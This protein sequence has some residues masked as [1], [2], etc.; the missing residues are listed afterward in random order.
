MEVGGLGGEVNPAGGGQSWGAG[1]VGD[2]EHASSGSVGASS[3]GRLR[4]E[5]KCVLARQQGK[6]SKKAQNP[7]ARESAAL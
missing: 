2:M 1:S 7:F 6:R 5:H 4:L 3:P